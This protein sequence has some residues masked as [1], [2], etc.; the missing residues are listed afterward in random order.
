MIQKLIG[1]CLENEN[2]LNYKAL[3]DRLVCLILEPP[4][5]NPH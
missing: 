1:M 2:F 4:Y 3:N 5:A